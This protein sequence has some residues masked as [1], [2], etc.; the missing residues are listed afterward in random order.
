MMESNRG[1]ET[2]GKSIATRA[3]S[4][5]RNEG[6]KRQFMRKFVLLFCRNGLLSIAIAVSLA[7]C[8]SPAVS[9]QVPNPPGNLHVEIT[10]QQGSLASASTT[11]I[12]K[13][14]D[15]NNN[16]IEFASGETV[17]CNGTFLAFHDSAFLGLHVDSYMGQV[18]IPPIGANY[19][20]IYRIPSGTKASIVVP[21]QKPPVLVF[22]VNGARVR[23]PQTAHTL[24]ITYAPSNSHTLS[25]S[26]Q[27][28]MGHEVSGKPEQDSGNYTL[29]DANFSMFAPGA[30]AISLTQEWLL[31]PPGT[32]FQSVH[33]AYNLTTTVQM[34]WI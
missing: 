11:L 2:S 28:S 26:A 22:P 19:T 15:A 27:D 16:F 10:I 31:T 30:G 13:F 21:S 5:I 24:S 4:N 7:S 32:G 6:A 25:G 9:S 14:F 20:C 12:V 23:I 3:K 34:I 33:V 8:L 1:R 18:P 29:D 17:A